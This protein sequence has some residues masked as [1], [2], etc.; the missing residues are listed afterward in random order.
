MTPRHPIGILKQD[1]IGVL[2]QESGGTPHSIPTIA[3][4]SKK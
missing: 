3:N 2:T 1:A 4:F